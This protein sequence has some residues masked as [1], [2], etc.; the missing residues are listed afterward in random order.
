MGQEA[1]PDYDPLAS[2]QAA[3]PPGAISF[4]YGL[5]DPGAFPARELRAAFDSVLRARSSLALQYGPEQGYGPL[6]DYLRA[7][8]DRDEDLGIARGNLTVTAGASQAIDHACTLFTRPGEIVLTETPSYSETLKLLR[9]HGLRPLQIPTDEGGVQIDALQ[10]RLKQLVRCGEPVRM[11][12]VIPCH[13]NPTGITLAAERRQAL[14]ELADRYDLYVVE[15][16]VYRDLAFDKPPPPSLFAL[17]EHSRVLRVGSFSKLLAP[18]LRLGWT[19]GPEGLIGR[20]IASGLRSMGGGANPLT[21]NA[22]A[23]YCQQGLLESH[24]ERLRRIY[25]ARRDNMLEALEQSMPDGVRWTRP[26]GGFFVW[27][28]LPRPFRA[29]EVAKRAREFGVMLLAGDPFFAEEPTG[30]FLRL[31]FSYVT[32]EKIAEGI[33]TLGEVLMAGR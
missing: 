33:E 21:A 19:M 10:Q 23:A 4:V 30:Q 9:D 17:D 31:S 7:K 28:S 8:F 24:I 11:L 15:D 3:G 13:Q 5:P 12:Y 32:P 2:V 16:D 25:R 20:M 29:I 6:I 14:L 18:G 1:Q 22:V 26:N 27:L